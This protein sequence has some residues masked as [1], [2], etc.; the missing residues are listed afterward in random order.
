MYFVYVLQSDVDKTFYVGRSAEIEN[1]VNEHNT[2]RVSYTKRKM[3]WRLVY[4]EAYSSWDAAKERE[5]Q[6]KRFGS[7]YTGL[8]KRLKLK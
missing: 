5:D 3:P 2:G 1:R 8:M 6:L 7:S 4:Y